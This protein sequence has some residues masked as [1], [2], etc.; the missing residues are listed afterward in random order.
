MRYSIQ[1]EVDSFANILSESERRAY[2]DYLTSAQVARLRQRGES[3]A[4]ALLTE[5]DLDIERRALKSLARGMGI[6]ALATVGAFASETLTDYFDAER[7]RDYLR[8]VEREEQAAQSAYDYD[9]YG[10]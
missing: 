10:V 5:D 7:E 2:L 4:R 6:E 3:F 9:F 8:E 1:N